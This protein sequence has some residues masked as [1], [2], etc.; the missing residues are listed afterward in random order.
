MR[1]TPR[2]VYFL[3]ED[4]FLIDEIERRAKIKRVSVSTEIVQILREHLSV[5]KKEVVISKQLWNKLQELQ[6]ILT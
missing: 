3:E 5:N 2:S 4:R 1:K 6:S